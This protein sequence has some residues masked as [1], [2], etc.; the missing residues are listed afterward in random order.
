VNYYR[1]KQVDLNGE[2]EY[3]NI[4]TAKVATESPVITVLPNPVQSVA[5]IRVEMEGLDN[6]DLNVINTNGKVVRTI[7][8][9]NVGGMEEVNLEDL[10]AGIYFITVQ[11]N[12]SISYKLIKQ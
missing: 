7:S 6:V 10:P 9:N 1:L 2:Y 3:F 8:I 11:N 4:V 5:N 12:T